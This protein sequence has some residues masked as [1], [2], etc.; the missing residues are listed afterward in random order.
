MLKK[1]MKGVLE[2]SMEHDDVCRACVLGKYAMET[3]SRSS[4][5]SDGVL[6]R[7]HSNI[8]GPMSSF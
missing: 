2:L 6:Q 4:G 8:C 5:R 3:F 1:T 7:T